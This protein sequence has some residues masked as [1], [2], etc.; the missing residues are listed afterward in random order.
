M[1]NLKDIITDR[2]RSVSVD[3]RGNVSNIVDAKIIDDIVIANKRV[4]LSIKADKND[5]RG[6]PRDL[7][8]IRVNNRSV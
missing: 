8:A 1:P 2:L 4:F 6:G 3:V 5:I 7:F